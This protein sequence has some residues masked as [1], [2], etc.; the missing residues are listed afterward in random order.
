MN[1]KNILC[2]DPGVNGGLTWFAEGFVKTAPMVPMPTGTK[3]KDASKH[4]VHYID[5]IVTDISA[6]LV[7]PKVYIEQVGP[8]RFDTPKTAWSLSMNYHCIL[9]RLEQEGWEIIFVTPSYWQNQLP[10][11]LPSGKSNYSKR[12]KALQEFAKSKYP[13]VMQ[14]TYPKGELKERLTGVSAKTADSTCI[15]WVFSNDR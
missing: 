10:I 1:N 3:G 8:Q 11:S 6:D 2:I 9:S 13:N 4:Q 12:K 15:Y 14:S 5:R 7:D